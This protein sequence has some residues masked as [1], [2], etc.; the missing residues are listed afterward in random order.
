MFSW[1]ICLKSLIFI[2]FVVFIATLSCSSGPSVRKRNKES[3]KNSSEI[4]STEILGGETVAIRGHTGDHEFNKKMK[5]L[6]LEVIDCYKQFVEGNEAKEAILNIYVDIDYEG[7]VEFVDY[8]IKTK[9]EKKIATCVL[10]D[11]ET[12]SFRPGQERKVKYKLVYTPSKRKKKKLSEIDD[13]RS[14]MIMALPDMAIFKKCYEAALEKNPHSGG[15]FTLSFMITRKG[16]AVDAKII[17]NSFRNPDVPLCIIKRLLKTYFPEG[18][19]DD[20]VK[21][22][23]KYGTVAPATTTIRERKKTMDIDL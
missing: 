10:G 15:N 16:T 20:K 21:I 23:F 13:K 22:K 17:N 4:G 12:L 9:F 2:V 3:S 18:D 1:E 11:I 6:D 7:Y 14:R 8:K 5:L 19:V